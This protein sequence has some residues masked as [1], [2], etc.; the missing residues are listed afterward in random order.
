[1]KI[2]IAGANGQLGTELQ[3]QLT[4]GKNTIAA[5]PNEIANADVCCFDIDTL[6]I[7]DKTALEQYMLAENPDVVINCS[8]YTNVDGCEENPQL[9]FAV[10]A[11]GA[12]NM[13]I[14]CEKANAKLIHISTDYVFSGEA[15]TPYSE[16]DVPNPQSVYGKSKWAGEEY[17]KAFCSKRF[18][19]RTAWLYGY[20]G[21][22]FVKTMLR[23]LKQN[24]AAKV[25]NDQVGNPTNAE[26]L[27]YHLL[28]L[29]ITEEYGTYHCTGEGVCSWYDFTKEIARL[30]NI[31]AEVTPCTTEEFPRPAKRPAFS[32]LENRMLTATIGNH[33]RPW[34]EALTIF[35]E[36]YQMED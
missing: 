6:S 7:T 10:N 18:I 8:A 15:S 27:A 21:G 14:A 12:R 2:M 33:M 34:Q 19:V 13:A 4:A 35:F 36:H 1:M 22:N 26:D 30:A 24:G 25:V 31:K 23:V 16:Y 5:L 11:V 17:V 3:R 28:L 29:A 9:A 32:A 20:A